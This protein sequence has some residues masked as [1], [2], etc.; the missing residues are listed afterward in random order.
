MNKESVIWLA[1]RVFGVYLIVCGVIE[2]PGAVSCGLVARNHWSWHRMHEEQAS[3][4]T[5][6]TESRAGAADRAMCQMSGL[7]SAH[8]MSEA[9]TKLCG[10]VL[11]IGCGVYCVF[12]GGRLFS[13]VG[14]GNPLCETERERDASGNGLGSEPG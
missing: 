12:R 3:R 6:E 8:S 1:I 13:L 10:L 4:Y 14:M 2:A 7:I 5:A 11:F 9:I